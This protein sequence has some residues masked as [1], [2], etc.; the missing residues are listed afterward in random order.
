[1]GQPFVGL[2]ACQVIVSVDVSLRATCLTEGSHIIIHSQDTIKVRIQQINEQ[3]NPTEGEGKYVICH[4]ELLS[5]FSPYFCAAL[6]GEFADSKKKVS[7][8]ET[9]YDALSMLLNWLYHGEAYFAY[10]LSKTISVLDSLVDLYIL[11]DR[12]DFLAVRRWVITELSHTYKLPN[13]ETVQRAFD[14]L[15][16][17][18]SDFSPSSLPQSCWA[19][20][21]RTNAVC[22]RFNLAPKATAIAA[23]T[24]HASTMNMRAMWNVKPVSAFI[25][26][27]V[28]FSKLTC[29]SMH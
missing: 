24:I 18:G 12:Y 28:T 7:D 15:R 25:R 13:K 17:T 9:T 10:T 3:P 22:S 21:R 23:T 4:K 16:K 14:S 6:T 20:P 1:M 2:E 29:L 11:A 8:V 27:C 26:L 5:F 19:T